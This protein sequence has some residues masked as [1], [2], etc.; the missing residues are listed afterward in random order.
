MIILYF[1]LL[2][3][4]SVYFLWQYSSK[5]PSIKNVR[6]QGWRG[7]VKYGHFSDKEEGVLQMQTSAIFGEKASDF[8]KFMVCPHG[9]GG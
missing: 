4:V 6:S 1:M 5:G 9:Q 2:R 3:Y 7:F 8:L